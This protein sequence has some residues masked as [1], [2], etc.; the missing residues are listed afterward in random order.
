MGCAQSHAQRWKAGSFKVNLRSGVWCDFATGDK[1]GDVIDLQ[2]Y[3]E[4]KSK[5]EAARDLATMLNVQST[6]QR[7]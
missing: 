5:L 1:G 6:A 4:G 3:L 2:A 7:A